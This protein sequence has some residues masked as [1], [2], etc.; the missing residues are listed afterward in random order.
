LVGERE[1]RLYLLDPDKVDYLESYGNYV[2]IW[3]GSDSYISRDRVKELAVRLAPAGFVRIERSILV[4]I[5][6]VAYIER[7]GHGMYS[8]TLTSG[9]RLESTPTY[10][11]EILRAVLPEDLS[12]RQGF[13]H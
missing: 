12:K 10:R 7:L 3:T 8:F 9:T 11:S 5:R 1:R 4:N 2:R 13:P 6:A